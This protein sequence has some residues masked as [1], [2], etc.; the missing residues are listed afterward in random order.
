MPTRPE[1]YTAF[2]T[3][4]E[5][6]TEISLVVTSA[7][8]L[9]Q[10]PRSR[11]SPPSSFSALHVSAARPDCELGAGRVVASEKEAKDD[12]RETS[13]ALVSSSETL[14]LGQACG[15]GDEN[16]RAEDGR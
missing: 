9:V 5:T 4:Q 2:Y 3:F 8:I 7:S 1:A 16:G 14:P 15:K 12:D 13:C 6:Q 11:L 10:I